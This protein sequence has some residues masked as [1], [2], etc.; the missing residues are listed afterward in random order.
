M[1]EIIRTILKDWTLIVCMI[2]M[3]YAV[4]RFSPIRKLIEQATTSFK[5]GAGLF[6]AAMI[7]GHA[8]HEVGATF[9]FV[10]WRMYTSPTVMAKVRYGLEVTKADQNFVSIGVLDESVP[11]RSGYYLQRFARLYNLSNK[12]RI[13]DPELADNY[14]L[15]IKETIRELVHRNMTKK[16]ETYTSARFIL[17]RIQ[18]DFSAIPETLIE[19]PITQP[20]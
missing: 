3:L 4:L 20:R 2:G 9:P 14:L 6:I 8:A 1:K 17:K 13:K 15:Q 18:K 11:F 16:G 5:V 10:P 7:I 19:V 12:V